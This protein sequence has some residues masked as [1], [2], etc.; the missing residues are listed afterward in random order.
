MTALDV[1]TAVI[2]G[3]KFT[4]ALKVCHYHLM[5]MKRYLLA[6]GLLYTSIN[7]EATELVVQFSGFTLEP[8]KVL[9]LQLHAVEDQAKA[10]DSP[11]LGKYKLP[12]PLPDHFAFPNLSPGDYALRGF[13][14]LNSNAVLDMNEKARP[15]EP[16]GF[17]YA[18]DKKKPSLKFRRAL[19]NVGELG[20]SGL[21]SILAA[22]GCKSKVA[23]CGS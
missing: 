8:G 3:A 5:T 7:S 6:L 13:V 10:W 15:Q 17:S 14:D 16:F 12:A 4:M 20:G 2:S 1:M 19:I 21:F 9:Y 18:A 11:I 23:G 22:P